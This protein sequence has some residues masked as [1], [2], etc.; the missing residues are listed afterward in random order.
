QEEGLCNLCP[1]AVLTVA[2]PAKVVEHMAI[3]QLFDKNPAIDRDSSPCGFCLSTD[4]FCTI[5][6]KRSKGAEGASRIDMDRSRCPNLGNLGLA[7]AAQSSTKNPCTNRPLL[8][9]ISPCPDVVWKYNLQTHIQTVHPSANISNYRSYYQLAEGEEVELKRISTTK[10]RKS[11]KKK[12]NF[13]ISPQH[14]TQAV[15]G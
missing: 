8:C 15:L 3:H 7:T 6:L 12:I 9:P 5:V 14:S 1:T 4:S 11:S 13:R 10:R 2:A